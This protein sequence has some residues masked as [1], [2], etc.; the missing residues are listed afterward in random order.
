MFIIFVFVINF[1]Y[2]N[3]Y[4]LV[5]FEIGDIIITYYTPTSVNY[6][7]NDKVCQNRFLF[8]TKII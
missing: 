1:S 3:T 5:S 8:K 7:Y 4:W 2:S 6:L